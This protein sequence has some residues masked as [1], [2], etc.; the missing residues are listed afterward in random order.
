[1]LEPFAIGGKFTMEDVEI[2]FF[3]LDAVVG[4]GDAAV[5]GDRA[6]GSERGKYKRHGGSSQCDRRKCAH[7]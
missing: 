5:L 2:D 4:I 7:N 1:M 6:I 3:A